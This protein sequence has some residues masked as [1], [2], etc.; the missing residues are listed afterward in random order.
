M[1]AIGARRAE[2]GQLLSPPPD[3]PLTF[4]EAGP[5]LFWRLPCLTIGARKAGRHHLKEEEIKPKE[6]CATTST[7]HTTITTVLPLH[8]RAHALVLPALL[9]LCLF[10]WRLLLPTAARGEDG[11]TDGKIVPSG[12]GQVRLSIWDS[13]VGRGRTLGP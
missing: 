12:L 8:G 3:P 1:R 13:W 5:P 9:C 10:L 6:G 2:Q 11:R 7:S 4:G